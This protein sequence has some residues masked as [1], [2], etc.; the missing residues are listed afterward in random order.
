MD[1]YRG[2][3]SHRHE[4][5]M[6]YVQVRIHVHVHVHVHDHDHVHVKLILK[7][8]MNKRCFYFYICKDRQVITT[9]AELVLTIFLEIT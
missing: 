1:G 4:H 8:P 5:D 6:N 9:R 3:H 2:N 7:N